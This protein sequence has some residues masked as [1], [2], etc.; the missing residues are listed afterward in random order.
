MSLKSQELPRATGTPLWEKLG[1]WGGQYKSKVFEPKEMSSMQEDGQSSTP[2]VTKINIVEQQLLAGKC[3]L[4]DDESKPVKMINY[5]GDCESKDEVEPV[6][7][8]MASFLASNP[9]GVRYGSNSLL[10]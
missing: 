6:D 3:E 10:D 1:G 2:L 4:L 9:S 5:T 8:E 7:N